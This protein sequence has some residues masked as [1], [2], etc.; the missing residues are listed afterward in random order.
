MTARHAKTIQAR[1]VRL[2]AS[3]TAVI[4]RSD[5]VDLLRGRDRWHLTPPE[6]KALATV[7]QQT[8]EES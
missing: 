4:T 6:A 5:G 8:E 7:L 1:V 2:S 3:T